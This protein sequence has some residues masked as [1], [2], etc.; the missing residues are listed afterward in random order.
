MN[1]ILRLINYLYQM[2]WSNEKYA[3]KLGV[4]IGKDCFISTRGFP[5]ESYL[6][7]IG[8]GCR[9]ASKVKFFTHGGLWAQRKKNKEL[10][11]DI[12]G[13]IK[14]GNYTY[15]GEGAMI[16]P[17]VTIGNDCII[18]AGTVVTKSVPDN[19]MVGGNPMKHIGKTDEFIKRSMSISADTYGMTPHD[20]RKALLSMD[21]SRFMKKS[22]IKI[23][24]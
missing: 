13:K 8:D 18:G 10:K 3:K 4:K 24:E 12:F 19:C 23:N 11:L 14:I 9:V 20:K 21:D 16:M 7:E 22:Y 5:S 6:I 15:I 2:T 17:G 1:K